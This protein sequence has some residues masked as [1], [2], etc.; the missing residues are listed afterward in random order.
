VIR[1][2]LG[3]ATIVAVLTFGFTIWFQTQQVAPSASNGA[4]DAPR[5][6]DTTGGQEMRPRWDSGGQDHDTAGN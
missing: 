5:Q 4:V 2:V 3:V 6:Y 1:I